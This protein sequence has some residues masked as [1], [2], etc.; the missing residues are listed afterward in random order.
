MNLMG[1]L[2]NNLDLSSPDPA[3]ANKAAQTQ[4]LL[5]LA[6]G[7]LQP[8]SLSSAA[9]SALPQ[10][11]Q[12]YNGAQQQ[13]RGRQ[14][15]AL[16]MQQARVGLEKSQLD[17]ADAQRSRERLKQVD[18]LASQF[19]R[20][21]QQQAMAANG[22]PTAAAAQA[23]ST[24]APGYDFQ[25]YAQALA[26]LD[27]A[28]AL[29]LQQLLRKEQSKL[30]SVEPMRGANGALVNVALFEDGTTKVLPYGVKPDIALQQLGDRVVAIDRNATAGGQGFAI[31]Q[32]PDSRAANGLGW[33]RL[34]F[35]KGK[36]AADQGAV[37][38]QQ[39]G[40]GNFVALPTRAHPGEVIRGRQVVAPGAGMIPLQGKTAGMTEGQAKANMFGSRMA[41]ADRI[42]TDL[43]AN[44]V[45][46]PSLIKRG[47]EAVPLLGGGL[48]MV[49]NGWAASSKQQQV[50]QAQRDFLNAVL[51]RE[52]GA[53]IGSSEFD[54]ARVQYFPQPGDGRAV[55]EQK[56]RN[57]ALAVQTM[58]AEV[59]Q[60]QRTRL[61]APPAPPSISNW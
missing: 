3:A 49:A 48:G 52:S 44:G 30:K 34:A 32:S 57:R 18:G 38:Y 43:A 36:G 56:A 42:L 14:L 9:A 55:I 54:S 31:G 40:S 2:S 37:T 50:E 12:A 35:E 27:P 26:G 59:P 61:S 41:A 11:L 47:A 1:L 46:Q 25:G 21:P 53:A 29:A 15:D 45:E 13:I 5:T 16:Q 24:A 4:G 8:G 23:S 58:L 60:Q 17:L 7:L 22:G 20:S 39:D 6:A 10:A 28:K 33:A 51:R 19:V